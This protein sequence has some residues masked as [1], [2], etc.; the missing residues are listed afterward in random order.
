M[1]KITILFSACALISTAGA[2]A[3][4][5]GQA[6][7]NEFNPAISLILEGRYANFDQGFELPGYVVTGEAGIF[8]KGFSTGHN[9][10]I[11]SA[12]VDEN[13]YA[14]FTAALVNE[15]GESL[16]EVEEAFIETL[17]LGQGITLMTG[18]FYS[19]IGYLNNVH[20][21]T[22]DFA[23]LPLVYA[24]F[25]GNHLNE[26]GLQLRWLA[27]MDLFLEFG[28]EV[29]TGASWP[30]GET[31]DNNAGRSAFVKTGSDI[32]DSS[33]WLAGLSFHSVAFDLREGA[34]HAHGDG[35]EADLEFLG[36]DTTTTGIDLLYKWAP[37]GNP[38]ETNF[39]LQFE[40]FTRSEEAELEYT[41]AVDAGS[42]E[43]E[44]DQSGFYVQAVYQF[45]PRWRVGLRY[46]Q[47]TSDNALSN[48]DPAGLSADELG[49]ETELVTDHE[50]QRSTLMIDFSPSEFSRVRLQYMQDDAGEESE[51]R[52]YL[53]YLMNLGSHGA[54]SF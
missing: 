40:Y 3:Q 29:T 24:G 23:D 32:G 1:N 5:P 42:A 50:P 49:E 34:G 36:G 8:D 20:D 48:A 53:Q 38:R 44:G 43:Y 46:D 6:R 28:F 21:H 13:L 37:S 25:F 17:G 4:T 14:K 9:E 41:D 15:D 35:A 2:Q 39:K 54:H 7:G 12:N 52:V 33:S 10:L 27:P 31:E 30:G 11:M 47:L 18:Q 19:G 22:H 26:T 16:V 45:M 51:N